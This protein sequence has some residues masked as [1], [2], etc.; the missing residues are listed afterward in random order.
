MTESY[1]SEYNP[2]GVEGAIDTNNLPWLAMPGLDGVWIKPLR[3]SGESGF[4]SAIIKLDARASLPSA[5]YLGG[6]D[7]MV[8]SGALTYDEGGVQSLL[9]PGI[10]GYISANSRVDALVAKEASELLVNFYNGVAFLGKNLAVASVLTAIDILA[11]AQAHH[12]QLVPNTLAGCSQIPSGQF[13]GKGEPLAIA[14]QNAGA[15]V[16]ASVENAAKSSKLSHP[17]FVDTRQVPWAVVPELPDIGLKILRVSEET[18]VVSLIVRHNAVV[19]P[20]NH[21]GAGDFLILQGRMGYR[22]GPP[23][24]CGPGVWIFEPAGARHDE[25]QRLSDDDLIY[26]ANLY[27][28]LAFDTGRGT[29]ISAILSWMEYKAIAEA[30]GVRLVPSSK[31]GDATL[32]AWAPLG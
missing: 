11:L 3:A 4:F 17:H 29:P 5:V 13:T 16:A 8:L 31:D 9:A 6:L 2:T 10:W 1:N 18:G 27:G 7:L 15:L 28:P 22:A 20:H 19:P 30:F 21:I 24:G 23:E 12:I 26:T 14:H 32:L 25:T